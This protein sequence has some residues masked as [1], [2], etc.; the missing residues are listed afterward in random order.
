MEQKVV[1]TVD[2][3][4][5]KGKDP[6]D[7]L[8]WGNTKDGRYGI[9]RIMD[10]FEEV[11]VHILFFLDF[12]EAWDYGEDKIQA[13]ADCILSRGHDIGV[14]IHPDH[15]ADK[16]RLFLWQYSYDEQKFIIQKCTDLYQKIV[17]KAPLS[18]RAGK[19]SA[20][21]DTLDILCELG[22]KYD[23]SEYYGQKWCG[24]DP[25]ITVNSPVRYKDIIEFPVTMHQSIKLF[26]YSRFDKVD[27]ESMLPGELRYAL[28]QITAQE[29]PVII[30]L[31]LHSFSLMEWAN[32]PDDPV[33][34]EE[35]LRKLYGAVKTIS[36]N[37]NLEYISEKE[38]SK[39]RPESEEHA[40]NS[41]IIWKS[42]VKGIYYSYQKLKFIARRNNKAKLVLLAGWCSLAV[43]LMVFMAVLLLK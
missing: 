38:L 25:A 34:S 19:Y 21:K 23:F 42:K 33:K 3:E 17:G 30:T 14:H 16:D 5:H 15:M 31:F 2:T 10:A 1:V 4:S 36:A 28:N 32:D 43:M 22:Y 39:I 8:I 9:E 7:K 6:V 27:V 11:D 18:F 24:I 40:K 20:N 26:G 35:K 41:M 37:Q 29:F 12:A 13:V